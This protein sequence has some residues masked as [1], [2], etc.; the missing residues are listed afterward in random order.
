VNATI[1]AVKVTPTA[2]PPGAAP[3]DTTRKSLVHALP[4]PPLELD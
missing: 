2:T 1:E 3:D 4:R